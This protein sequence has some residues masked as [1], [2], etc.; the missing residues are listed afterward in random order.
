MYLLQQL[1]LSGKHIVDF[2]LFTTLSK[3]KKAIK[4]FDNLYE[5]VSKDLEEN[6][7]NQ[8]ITNKYE[9]IINIKEVEINKF[10]EI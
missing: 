6:G 9:F 8:F 2:G 3:C 4:D 1:E 7:Y 5:D 10:K